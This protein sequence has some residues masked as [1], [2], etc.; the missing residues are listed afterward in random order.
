VAWNTAINL[1]A[2]REPADLARRHVVDSLAGVVLL[3]SLAIRDFVDLGSGGG[4]PGI[5]LAVALGTE[6]GLLVD[7]VGKKARFLE[8]AVDVAGLAGRVAVAATRAEAL[9]HDAAQRGGW[10]GVTARAVAPLAEL[11]ELA[12]PLLSPGGSLVA[13]KGAALEGDLAAA[14]RAA[15]G[16]GS[17]P[18]EVVAAPVPGASGH[19]LVVVRKV[20]PT[21]PGYPR[22]PARRRRQPW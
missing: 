6:R 15:A 2:V 14:V 20:A 8:A 11:M 1:T 19:R 4:F 17:G 7:S 12:M 10:P 3:Q 22:D 21:P 5:P 9:A 16:L 13:W 18:P